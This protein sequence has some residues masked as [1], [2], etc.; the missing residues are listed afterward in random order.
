MTIID[1]HHSY[2]AV[3]EAYCRAQNKSPEA[4]VGKSVAEVW[5]EENYASHIKPRL[6][7]CF[8]GEEIHYQSWFDFA[9]MGFRLFDV[10]YYPF[11]DEKN[12]ITH[13]VVVS[14]DITDIE[15][16][17]VSANDSQDLTRPQ[18]SP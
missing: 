3:N 16:N 2:T 1:S 18:F 6:D 14:R 10:S 7:K 12:E 9:V 15:G 13:A 11:H 5:G 8:A 17:A 4:I